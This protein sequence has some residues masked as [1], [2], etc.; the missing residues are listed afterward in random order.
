M[1]SYYAVLWRSR[2]ETPEPVSGLA[3]E[4][5]Q[6]MTLEGFTQATEGRRL[7]VASA[8]PGPLTLQFTGQDDPKDVAMSVFSVKELS[9]AVSQHFK[10]K[11]L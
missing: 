6:A 7:P 11:R 3:C 4:A 9:D 1:R 5:G 10:I 8:F 2:A